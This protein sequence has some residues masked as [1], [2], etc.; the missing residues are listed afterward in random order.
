MPWSTI[1]WIW[2]EVRWITNGRWSIFNCRRPVRISWMCVQIIVDA[3]WM[4]QI[5]MHFILTNE[6]KNP[7]AE[8]FICIPNRLSRLSAHNTNGAKISCTLKF[9]SIRHFQNFKLRYRQI[10]VFRCLVE[11]SKLYK[12]LDG[13]MLSAGNHFKSACFVRC[14]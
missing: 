7:K 4:T 13:M 9:H 14:A 8:L 11:L 12:V 1:W 10:R 2:R 6:K 3:W 5:T